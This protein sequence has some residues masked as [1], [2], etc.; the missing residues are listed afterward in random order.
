MASTPPARRRAA[1]IVELSNGLTEL[2]A[3]SALTTAIRSARVLTNGINALKDC[4][5]GAAA[6]NLPPTA[7]SASGAAKS[8]DGHALATTLGASYKGKSLNEPPPLAKAYNSFPTGGTLSDAG[9][10]VGDSTKEAANNS[11]VGIALGELE[12]AHTLP[13]PNYNWTDDDYANCLA[14][15]TIG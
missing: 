13:G 1:S 6:G 14:A 15:E 9:V 5:V 8:D 12:L 7:P 10:V 2:G 4:T 3:P 11:K